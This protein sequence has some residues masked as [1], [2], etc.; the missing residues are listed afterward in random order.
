MLPV[1]RVPALLNSGKWTVIAGLFDPMTAAQG[2]R[3]ARCREGGNKLLAIVL[4]DGE[5]LLPA[6]ARAALVAAL[7]A[8][9]AV[10]IAPA[11]EWA[12][13]PEDLNAERARTAEFVQFV[14]DRA[15]ASGEA[16]R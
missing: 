3:I 1:E 9:D 14:I 5:T 16:E 7:R 6:G 2:Q 12:A 10:T 8:V 13:P 15:T 11:A 4:E